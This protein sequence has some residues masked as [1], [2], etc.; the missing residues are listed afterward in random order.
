MN[1]G[2]TFLLSLSLAWCSPAAMALSVFDVIE[3]TRNGY[4]QT[5]IERLIE[6]TNARFV[7]DVDGLLALGEAKVADEIIALMLDRGGMPAEEPSEADQ[8]IALRD[9]GFSEETILQ[10]VR[11]KNVCE[12]LADE[13][14]RR[15]G[16]AG[17][18]NAFMRDFRD[19]VED[20]REEREAVALIE[21][22]PEE[23]YEE[24]PSQV[25]RVYRTD[26]TVY[27]AT[28]PVRYPTTTYY[29]SRYYGIYDSYYYHD[30]VARVYPI[31]VY[32]DY[33]GHSRRHGKAGHRARDHDRRRHS[34]D[35]RR[36]DRDYS[37][38]SRRHGKAG[39]GA[40]DHDRRKHDGDRRRSDRRGDGQRGDRRRSD[41]DGAPSRPQPRNDPN[42]RLLVSEKPANQ[43]SPATS[44]ID[45]PEDVRRR[46]ERW[47]QDPGSS[48][49]FVRTG[50]PK[51]SPKGLPKRSAGTVR[52]HVGGE[53][54][55]AA[56][57]SDRSVRPRSPGLPSDVR[58]RVERRA[59]ERTAPPWATPPVRPGV[60]APVAPKPSEP[61][62]RPPPRTPPVT[63][64][65]AVKQPRIPP[66]APKA[67]RE[68]IDK[69]ETV[70]K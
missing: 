51:G 38:H 55:R 43:G 57:R 32:R 61:R 40:R 23:A 20:C 26:E 27:P 30:R 11:H 18:S 45:L 8:L 24:A 66:S 33:R 69:V 64:P 53:R 37:G 28:Y 3:L 21:P 56:E 4:D 14:A 41:S 10:F 34:Q 35:R 5:E 9:A 62:F 68:W 59:A 58:R 36:G 15:L 46:I 49:P 42:P 65:P 25:T 60:S 67:A 13:D 2:T 44:P 22:V 70:D 39:H 50:L 48:Q 29:P 16:Q 31:V 63:P 19:Q 17:F 1:R 54:R 12:P 7:I 6:V 47:Q 52:R